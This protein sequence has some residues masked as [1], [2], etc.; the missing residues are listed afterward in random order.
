MFLRCPLPPVAVTPDS[1]RQLYRG[2]VVPLNR[3]MTPTTLSGSPVAG[4]S[5]TIVVT[6]STTNNNPSK[7]TPPVSAIT[8]SFTTS[9][10]SMG[11]QFLSTLTAAKTFELI[12]LTTSGSAR[13]R[14][15]GTPSAQLL[16]MGR[17]DTTAP[18]IGTMQA[19]IA[20][21]TLD[22]SPF[23][24]LYTWIPVAANGDSPRTANIYV[25]V[26]GIDTVS[27]PITVTLLYLPN[28]L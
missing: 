9:S 21:V 18:N 17:P 19:L 14:I 20:D 8:A 4:G 10:L 11:D 12:Q 26:D 27:L 28:E 22:T 2:G 25:T 24:W 3:L 1:L 7:P 23:Q 5:G 13:V 16:D 15:Y 6:G